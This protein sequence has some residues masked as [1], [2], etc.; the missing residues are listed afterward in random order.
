MVLGVNK[1]V[2][3]DNAKSCWQQ[4]CGDLSLWGKLGRRPTISLV[5]GAQPFVATN[6]S[7]PNLWRAD[8]ERF[9]DGFIQDTQSS[10]RAPE[11]AELERENMVNEQ[12]S[13]VDGKDGDNLT[14]NL[15]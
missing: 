4:W 15:S 11:N 1:Y 9:E 13:L 6:V 7:S 3:M 12:P 2:I 10:I 8:P 5:E 14:P